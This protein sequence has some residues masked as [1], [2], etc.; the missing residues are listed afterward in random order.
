MYTVQFKVY[1]LKCKLLWVVN[2]FEKL[3]PSS[4]QLLLSVG[5]LD[6]Q[7]EA[8][9]LGYRL[10]GG[11]NRRGVKSTNMRVFFTIFLYC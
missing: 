1:S 6:R 4:G 5:E 3:H 9:Y 8:S 11:T 2:T 10:S 7:G